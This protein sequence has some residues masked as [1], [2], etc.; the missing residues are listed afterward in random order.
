MIND[1]YDELSY[2]IHIM[3]RLLEKGD[4]KLIETKGQTKILILDGKSFAWVSAGDIGE[5]LVASHKSHV[6][7]HFLA[8]GKYRMYDVEDEPNLADTQHLEL[9]VGEGFWQGY[10]LPTGLPEGEN[11]KN[12]II[13]TVET[14]SKAVG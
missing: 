8:I 7:D 11:K 5:I 2:C 1:L 4:Y 13:P 10:L 6:V 3:I 12:R 14:I 9:L